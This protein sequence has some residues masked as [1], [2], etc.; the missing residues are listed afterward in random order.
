MRALLAVL[1]LCLLP[2]AG[3]HAPRE[4]SGMRGG[5]C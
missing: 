1:I 5:F 4:P 3:A 2:V